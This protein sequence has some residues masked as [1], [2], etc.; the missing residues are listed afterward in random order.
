MADVES[1][2]IQPYFGGFVLETL[3]V[4]MYGESRNAIREY[5]QNGFDSIQSALALKLLKVGQG[6]IEIKLSGDQTGLIIRD[7]GT[8]ISVK[9][10][11][12]TLTSVGSSKK[13]YRTN[14]GFRGIGRLAGIVFSDKVLFTTKAHGE[15]QQTTIIF[16]ARAMRKAMSPAEGGTMSAEDLLKHCVSGTVTTASDL[17][18]HFFEVQLTGLENPPEECIYFRKM[19][20]FVSQIAPVP[21]SSKFKY[22]SRLLAAADK[23]GIPI[24]EVNVSIAEGSKNPVPATKPYTD[25]YKVGSREVS[26]RGCEI[27]GPSGGKWWGWVG[28]KQESGAYE[29]SRVSGLRVRVENIQIDSTDVIREVFQKRAKSYVRFTDYFVGEIFVDQSWLVPNARRDGFEEDSNWKKMRGELADVVKKLGRLAYDISTE[30]QKTVATLEGRL[31]QARKEVAILRKA[32]FKNTD[33]M[34]K[35][36]VDIT[37]WT[38]LVDKASVDADRATLAKLTAIGAELAD[39]KTECL[40]RIGNVPPEPDV[41]KVRQGARDELIREL[42]AVFEESLNPRCMSEVRTIL[43]EH[44]GQPEL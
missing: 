14:A 39:I 42:M 11:A 18:S 9:S 13:N 1:L 33:R 40:K 12:E 38:N 37:S 6:C 3:T 24:N 35:L 30:A 43:R 2:K 10:A 20:D 19:Q 32:A 21:Y 31:E 29:D 34:L 25:K 26:L 36:S 5:I 23:Y 44:L 41:E 4:G 27:I 7:N 28:K 16:D 15:K 17:D 8:G 22:R